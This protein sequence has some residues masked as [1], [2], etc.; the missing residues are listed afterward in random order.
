MLHSN[1]T[2]EIGARS[3][4]IMASKRPAAKAEPQPMKRPAC[5]EVKPQPMKRPAA[6]A[7]PQRRSS[8]VK[9]GTP[10]DP[11]V[12]SMACLVNAYSSHKKVLLNTLRE[13]GVVRFVSACSGSQVFTINLKLAFELLGKGAVEELFICDKEPS[14]IQ[15]SNALDVAIDALTGSKM[16]GTMCKF[17]EIMQLCEHTAAC[18]THDTK[19]QPGTCCPART[20]PGQIILLAIIGIVCTEFSPL[21]YYPG[22]RAK[23][24]EDTLRSGKGPSGHSFQ[25]TILYGDEGEPLFTPLSRAVIP[26][27]RLH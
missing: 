13:I 3:T 21:H 7:E 23:A 26:P 27:P 19:D 2:L 16:A 11:V 8:K 9:V 10:D 6:K 14:R 22:G 12:K 4:I 18:W 1:I 17:K 25:G 24:I 15:F 5:S 20:K